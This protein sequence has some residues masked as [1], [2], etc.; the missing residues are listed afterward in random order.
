MA[1]NPAAWNSIKRF[2]EWLCSTAP[3]AALMI[4]DIFWSLLMTWYDVWGTSFFGLCTAITK[5][6]K[7]LNSFC[8]DSEC[9]TMIINLLLKFTLYRIRRYRF[10]LRVRHF[11]DCWCWPCKIQLVYFWLCPQKVPDQYFGN[12][13]AT[14]Y[15]MLWYTMVALEFFSSEWY[16]PQASRTSNHAGTW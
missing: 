7:Y 4:F 16:T 10:L 12:G 8:A 13:H 14:C 3:A 9:S 6:C 1:F 11:A 5:L 15:W 2:L